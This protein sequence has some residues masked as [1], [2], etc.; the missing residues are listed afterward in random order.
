MSLNRTPQ[1][2]HGFGVGVGLLLIGFA[3]QTYLWY[4]YANASPS[5]GPIPTSPGF[6]IFYAGAF[7]FGTIITYLSFVN[8]LSHVLASPNDN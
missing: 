1:V 7:V 8:G 3:A 2:R 4:G 6:H 5:I